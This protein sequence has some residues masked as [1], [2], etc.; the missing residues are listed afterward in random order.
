MVLGAS[1]KEMLDAL[2]MPPNGSIV[3]LQ[4]QQK[5]I[6]KSDLAVYGHNYNNQTILCSFGLVTP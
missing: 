2:L 1:Y 6:C 3:T 5:V 4:G